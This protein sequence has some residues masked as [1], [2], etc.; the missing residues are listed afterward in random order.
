MDENRRRFLRKAPDEL[1]VIQIERDEVGKVLNISEGGLCFSSI[2]PVPRNLPVYFWFSFNLRDKIEAM[3]EVAWTDNSR[4]IGGLRFTQISQVGREQMKKWLS[5]LRSE[6]SFEEIEVVDEEFPDEE[7]VFA[8]QLVVTGTRVGSAQVR[9]KERF[10]LATSPMKVGEP[11]RVAKFVSKARAYRPTLSLVGRGAADLKAAV[12]PVSS[13]A[14]QPALTVNPPPSRAAVAPQPALAVA[15]PLPLENELPKPKSS[16]Y[17]SLS[18][19][20]G[21]FTKAG[22][23]A[24]S[25]LPSLSFK[26]LESLVELVPL[27]RYLSAKK[28]QLL[29]GV[30]LGVCL[31]AAVMIP[32]MKFWNSRAHADMKPLA[33]D[34]PS[35]K[36]N[37]NN[38]AAQSPLATSLTAATQAKPTYPVA[39]IFSDP[40]PPRSLSPK[41]GTTP[42]LIARKQ[43]PNA[44]RQDA[45]KANALKEVVAKIPK[46]PA[47][48]PQTQSNGDSTANKK[49]GMNPTQLWT[50]VQAG[51]SKAAVELAELYIRG[52]GVP[53][54]CQQARVLLL[55][56]SEK[57]NT[58]AIKRLQQLDK[59]TACP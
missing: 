53:R 52:D 19:M 28:R 24:D 29:C 48:A 35:L 42:N 26:G 25:K 47:V 37:N 14:P 23:L 27:Q 59:G 22:A 40:I 2:S 9:P 12:A 46:P 49:S 30:L 1:T 33:T 13:L 41:K 45:L 16:S 50:A 7:G 38:E 54:N 36:T 18:P 43:T 51:N 6:E 31:S 32:V 5:R 15:Q 17:R 39:G 34:Q 21:G 44:Y 20:E 10:R 11:D 57:R 55:V 4:T 3:G 56:A 58:A 8:G